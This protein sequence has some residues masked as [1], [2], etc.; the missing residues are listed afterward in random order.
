MYINNKYVSDVFILADDRLG[1]VDQSKVYVVISWYKNNRYQTIYC[2]TNTV[3][4]A[5]VKEVQ[6]KRAEGRKGEEFRII[7]CIL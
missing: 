7:C 5:G 3:S 4:T 2:V 1:F 6:L